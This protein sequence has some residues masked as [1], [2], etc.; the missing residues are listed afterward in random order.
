MSFPT[1]YTFANTNTNGSVHANTVVHITLVDCAIVYM[2]FGESK[3]FLGD[4]NV[5]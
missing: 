2:I 1:Y 4:I 5:W 3:P